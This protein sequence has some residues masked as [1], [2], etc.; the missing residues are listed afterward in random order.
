MASTDYV[1]D[2]GASF[3]AS[4]RSFPRVEKADGRAVS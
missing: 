4:I 2:V 3:L 1:V